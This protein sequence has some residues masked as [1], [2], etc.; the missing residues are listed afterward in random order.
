MNPDPNQANPL[1][2]TDSIVPELGNETP[3]SIEPVSDVKVTPLAP[4]PSTTPTIT[5]AETKIPDNIFSNTINPSAVDFPVNAEKPKADEIKTEE[6]NTQNQVFEK[7][8]YKPQSTSFLSQPDLNIKKDVSPISNLASSSIAPDPAQAPAPTSN[9]QVEKTPSLETPIVKDIPVPNPNPEQKL[10]NEVNINPVENLFKT[11]QQNQPSTPSTPPQ[12]SITESGSSQNRT[13]ITKSSF[14]KQTLILAGA[15]VLGV[16]I[17]GL[18]IIL[19]SN[20][21]QTPE[22]SSVVVPQENLVRETEIATTP[23]PTVPKIS[24]QDY[25][26]ISSE[27]NSAIKQITTSY[28]VDLNDPNLKKENIRIAANQIIAQDEKLRVLDISSSETASLNNTITSDLKEFANLHDE[29]FL[30]LNQNQQIT[31]QKRNELQAKYNSLK[32]KIET[33]FSKLPK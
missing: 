27:V 3:M 24:N 10:P 18:G 21:S 14:N 12:P 22:K 1:Q 8:E 20:L 13:S 23:A 9:P 2:P 25:I 33:N 28:P 6:I 5:P 11:P 19:I 16:L 29:I 17:V 31:L 15:G 32:I 4:S 7:N 30:I 26:I